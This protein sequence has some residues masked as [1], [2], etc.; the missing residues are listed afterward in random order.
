MR[1]CDGKEDERRRDIPVIVISALDEL[2]SVVRCIE[3][4]AEDYLAKPFDPVLLRARIG[5][6]LEKKRLR[7]QEVEYLAQVTRVTG[8]AAAVEGGTFEVAELDGVAG[9]PD[10]L[11]LLARVFQTMAREVRAREERLRQ[12]VQELTIQIDRSREAKAVA[13]ITE[14]DYF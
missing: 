3:M 2:S 9:R 10:A 8:A 14:T 13:E 6:C 11:G 1:Y 5:A 4:G 7:D 12:R